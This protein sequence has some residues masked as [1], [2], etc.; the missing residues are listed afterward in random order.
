MGYHGA[1]VGNDPE[2]TL[3]LTAMLSAE[4]R[5]E[6]TNNMLDMMGRLASGATRQQANA[7][8]QVRWQDFKQRVAATLPERDR[9]SILQERAA[10]LNGRNGFDPLR[11]RLLA[12]ASSPHRDRFS[13]P[14][15]CLRE[16][17]GSI[18]GAGC[19]SRAR[20]IDPPRDR[21]ESE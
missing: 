15:A 17:L 2:I 6:P 21:R 14:V 9:P 19:L 12:G 10:V 16:P 1:V 7:E 20:D 3:P 8:L 18:A 11:D 4:N 13:C 5:N